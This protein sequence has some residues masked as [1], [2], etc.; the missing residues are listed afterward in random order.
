[1]PQKIRGARFHPQPGPLDSPGVGRYG[2]RRFRGLLYL[3]RSETVSET[4]PSPTRRSTG[5]P[6][7]AYEA[8]P[9]EAY[10]PYIDPAESIG[11]FSWKAVLLGI[12]IGIVFGAANAYLGLRVGITV[13]ASIPAAVMAIVLFRAFR[14]GTVLETNI[15][16]TVGSAGESLAAGVIFTIPAIFIWG[17]EPDL[18]E[19]S[20]L[21]IIGGLLGVLFMI[22][23]RRFLI[24]GEHGALPYPEGLATAEVQVAGEAG[25]QRGRLVFGGLGVGAAY[26]L[27]ANGRGLSLWPDEPSVRLPAKAEIAGSFT[28][29]LLGV[30]FIIGPRI[31]AIMFGGGAL[32]WLIL[33]PLI[34]VW[35]G[36]RVVFPGTIPVSDMEPGEI[37]HRYVRYVGAGGVAFGGLVTLLKG[38]PTIWQSFRLG[39]THL[40]GGAAA[41]ETPRTDRDIGYGWIVGGSAAA[42]LAIW[43]WPGIP[44]NLL[45]A[46]LLVLF[47]FF[48]VTVSSRIVGL[49]GSTSNP[50][51]GM[52]IATLL[53]ISLI[54]VG[55]GWDERPDARLAALSVG[56]VVAIAAAIAGDTSQDLKAGFLLGATPWKQ[57]VG[58]IIGVL[59]SALVMGSVLLLLHRSYGIGTEGGLPAPQATLM[60]L[61][62]DGVLARDLP[63][64]FVF[65]GMGLAA[66]VEFG[67]RLPS[68]AFAVGLYLPVALTTPII[69]GGVLRAFVE[70]TAPQAERAEQREAG[71]L[72]SSGL[73]AG[74]A[75]LGVVIAGA[76][77]VAGVFDPTLPDRWVLGHQWMGVAGGTLIGSAVFAALVYLLHRAARKGAALAAEDHAA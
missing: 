1:M 28:P 49:V 40:T 33:I 58:E 38:L 71:I 8:V 54:F 50:I 70:R 36:G 76:I 69:I 73:V 30:G 18:I 68:L 5:L 41:A 39:L 75:L 37:W 64:A 2:C 46:A 20:V 17:L 35:G 19:I 14:T 15:V 21:A 13:S 67:L 32:A 6:L 52:T 66:V 45:T 61:V 56:A 72:F 29:E 31:A 43:L 51:S 12:V 59:T 22:P 34:N 9:G 77:Y 44:V 65:V 53:L 27:M 47:T 25:G 74:A 11:E 24:K 23:L 60:S 10:R 62:I 3:C 48:F 4:A 55:L 63:W 16:Q 26:Q 7:E 42:A 57:Q